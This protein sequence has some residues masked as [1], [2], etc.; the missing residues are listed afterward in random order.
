LVIKPVTKMNRYNTQDFLM[1]FGISLIIA[2]AIYY[3]ITQTAHKIHERITQQHE[4]N[5]LLRKLTGE[6]EVFSPYIKQ[7]RER[8]PS[9]VTPADDA[10]KPIK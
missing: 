2:L 6:P 4:T 10:V 1:I 9:T 7:E 5:R 8:V 3:W